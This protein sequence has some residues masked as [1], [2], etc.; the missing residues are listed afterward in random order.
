MYG[1]AL[2]N[3][4]LFVSDIIAL[5]SVLIRP[6]TAE[7]WALEG[8]TVALVLKHPGFHLYGAA[9]LWNWISRERSDSC[10]LDHSLNYDGTRH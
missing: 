3:A 7:I 5:Y 4:A 9:E 2:L 10:G 1:I 8:Y 6:T